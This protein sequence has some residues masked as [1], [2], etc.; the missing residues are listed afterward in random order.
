MFYP[1]AILTLALCA[2]AGTAITIYLLTKGNIGWGIWSGLGSQCL[3]LS[4]IYL[5]E[6]WAFLPGDIFIFVT[7]SRRIYF[8]KV[9]EMQRKNAEYPQ[10]LSGKVRKKNADI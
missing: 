8:Q 7:Y 1:D 2:N 3:W 5:T 9:A 4:Y 10:Y 6:A